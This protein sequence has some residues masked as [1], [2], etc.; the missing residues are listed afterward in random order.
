[1]ASVQPRVG[2]IVLV[3]AVAGSGKTSTLTQFCC[4]QAVKGKTMLLISFSRSDAEDARV[5]VK[6]LQPMVEVRTF[7]SIVHSQFKGGTIGYEVNPWAIGKYVSSHW[8]QVRGAF[9]T[10]RR[11]LTS[12]KRKRGEEVAPQFAP[13]MLSRDVAVGVVPVLQ[14][15][16]AHGKEPKEAEKKDW[17]DAALAAECEVWWAKF[18]DI[19]QPLAFAVHEAVNLR[20]RGPETPVMVEWA[21][22]CVSRQ[23]TPVKQDILL[24]DEVQD[25]NPNMVRWVKAQGHT[26]RL[27][28][29]DLR[30][31]IFQFQHTANGF[32]EFRKE[33]D[34]TDMALTHSFRFGE[35]IASYVNRRFGTE[36]V[37]VATAPGRVVHNVA[38]ETALCKAKAGGSVTM[39]CRTNKKLAEMLMAVVTILMRKTSPFEPDAQDWQSP[40][41]G[42]P[43]IC[44]M[45]LRDADVLDTEARRCLTKGRKGYTTALSEVKTGVDRW[46]CQQFG[47]A[48]VIEAA[49]FLK[50]EGALVQERDTARIVLSTIHRFKG[51]ESSVVFLADDIKRQ[52]E[53]EEE[54]NILYTGLT[55]ARREVMLA[56][57]Q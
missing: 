12:R 7:D 17:Q 1:M 6:N 39:L 43:S 20:L 21:R 31:H 42:A 36:L 15:L 5:R 4:R 46:I 52:P 37:G 23:A 55:R 26:F 9:E 8:G 34:C 29:G 25:L 41:W 22:L 16:L 57:E 49:G 30:Q 50:Q 2:A 54:T 13:F 38:V 10:P 32:A 56:C 40:A 27:M 35:Q 47:A 19:G 45:G 53:S 48:R 3:D 24:V 14:A 51:K 18:G 33:Q 44:V 28:C 11:Y